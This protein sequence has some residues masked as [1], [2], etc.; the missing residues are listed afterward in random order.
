MIL[1]ELKIN[2]WIGD[3]TNCYIVFDEESKETMVI[4]PAG[5]VDKIVDLINIL[6]GKLKYIY[7]THCHGDHILGV[8]ELKNKCG[9]KILIHREDSEGLNDARINLTPYIIEKPIELEA[10]SRID[11]NDLIH[12]GNLEFRVIHTPGHT[13]GGTSLYCEKEGLLFSGD[14]LFRGTWGRTDCPTGSLEDIMDSIV[15]KLMKLPDDTICYPGHGLS[16]KI[17]DEKPIYLEL[18]PKLL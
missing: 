17:R 9:G 14:T 12:L 4:D 2:T 18:K 8:T 5:D 15:N 7:L 16:T 10:D 3:P 11:D 6:G 13:K 1:K